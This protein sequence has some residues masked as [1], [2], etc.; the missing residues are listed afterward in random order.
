MCLETLNLAIQMKLYVV[1]SRYAIYF[2]PVS[3]LFLHLAIGHSRLW[4]QVFILK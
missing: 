3:S 1:I 4:R 2:Q